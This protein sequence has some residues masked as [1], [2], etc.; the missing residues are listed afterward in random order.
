MKLASRHFLSEQADK[1]QLLDRLAQIS[2]LLYG[3]ITKKAANEDEHDNEYDYE[4][5][6]DND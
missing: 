2:N 6:L 1:S 5:D 3:I 4:Q